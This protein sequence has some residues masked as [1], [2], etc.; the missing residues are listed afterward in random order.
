MQESGVD[1]EFDILNDIIEEFQ[2][3]VGF[4]EIQSRT[5][6]DVISKPPVKSLGI[7]ADAILS[8]LL[9][10]V[11]NKM[12]SMSRTQQKL[13]LQREHLLKQEQKK[14]EQERLRQLE[15]TSEI[16]IPFPRPTETLP[17][18]IPPAVLNFKTK[19]EN[20]TKYYV[21]KTQERKLKEYINQHGT[22]PSQGFTP[23]TSHATLNAINN[24]ATLP[25]VGD[26]LGM[27]G[28]MKPPDSPMSAASSTEPSE[29]DEILEDIISLEGEN[30][31]VA[32]QMGLDNNFDFFDFTGANSTLP[33]PASVSDIYGG[34]NVSAGSLPDAIS[35]S[36]PPTIKQEP[37]ES[38]GNMQKF[39]HVTFLK[40]RQ[41]KDNHNMIER[42]RRFNINDRIKELGT[43]IPKQDTDMK[44]NKG[45]IL[46]CTVDY[47]KYLK[48]ENERH[49]ANLEKFRETEELNSKLLLRIQEL[50]MHCRA[51]N[52]PV[53]P[54][55]ND[56][57]TATLSRLLAAKRTTQAR[58]TIK[59][60]AYY[61]D[62][63]ASCSMNMDSF[64]ETNNRFDNEENGMET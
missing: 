20:P 54:L 51:H 19:L 11:E 43:M 42:R 27:V 33:L 53:T 10:P 59:P 45:T 47:I 23:P 52:V 21:Y 25:F 60:E 57:S 56:T 30:T 48:R 24:M 40:D 50:E 4:Y 44:Q 1:L 17:P 64:G 46:K 41:K 7:G 55:T 58:L 62:D 39:D 36:C 13:A 18:H 28:A 12:A 2:P 16:S 14:K 8:E 35:S 37:D 29:V 38:C 9:K 6:D 49:K 22:T 32:N 15:Q 63:S 5:L 34:R 61:S 3:K 31:H 26:G